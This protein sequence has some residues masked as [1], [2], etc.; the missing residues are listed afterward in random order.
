MKKMST[1]ITRFAFTA[2]AL[3]TAL[4]SFQ[5]FAQT[6]L[7]TDVDDT[8]KATHVLDKSD[9]IVNAFT[10]R[11]GFVGMPELYVNILEAQ[12]GNSMAYLS[13]APKVLFGNLVEE[14]LEYYRYPH[15]SLHL[16]PKL[17]SGSHKV[18]TLRKL[19]QER[20]PETVVLIGDNGEKDIFVYDQIR[21]EFES[22]GYKFLIFIRVDYSAAEG[23]KKWLKGQIP[24]VTPGEI[25]LHLADRG[26][27]TPIKALQAV[28]DSL[29]QENGLEEKMIPLPD[30]INCQEHVYDL[31]AFEKWSPLVSEL[32]F[33]IF[34]RCY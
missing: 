1:L 9:A 12:S 4:F 5:V 23:G 30:W 20:K 16:N 14:F 18:D 31:S 8:I 6:L 25:A 29:V 11:L 17:S 3:V 28:E 34:E 19:I 24:F 13:N 10:P 32:S 33:K 21:K 26:L 7:V 27:L 2:L 22:K 15:G